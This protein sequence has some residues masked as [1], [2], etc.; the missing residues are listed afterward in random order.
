MVGG[1]IYPEFMY[2]ELQR[3][4]VR[5]VAIL[6]RKGIRR[7][8]VVAVVWLVACLAFFSDSWTRLGIARRLIVSIH[9]D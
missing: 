7:G 5:L 1:G 6:G 2:E 3:K 8:T 4:Q 9:C